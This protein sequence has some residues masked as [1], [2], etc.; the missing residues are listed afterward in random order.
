[1]QQLR[2]LTKASLLMAIVLCLTSLR[3]PKHAFYVSQLGLSSGA[4]GSGSDPAK[5]VR[6]S[7]SFG[8]LPLSFEANEGQ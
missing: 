7:Q 2:A 6:L 4:L 3:F 8:K 5:L 1:M